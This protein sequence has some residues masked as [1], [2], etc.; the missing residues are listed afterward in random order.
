MKFTDLE[1]AIDSANMNSYLQERYA[2]VQDANAFMQTQAPWVKLKEESTREDGI[3]DLQHL[4]WIIK[5]LTLLSAPFLTNSFTKVQEI[6]R[7]P[8]LSQID[9]SANLSDPELFEKVFNITEFEVNLLPDVVYQKK[10]I[11]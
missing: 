11:I 6:L 1:N 10:E 7:N 2:A 8:L 4:L 9:S 3:Q 5:Q